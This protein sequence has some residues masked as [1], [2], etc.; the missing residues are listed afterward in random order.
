MSTWRMT[1]MSY[2][3]NIGFRN[4]EDFKIKDGDKDVPIVRMLL[5]K[6]ILQGVEV[7][8]LQQLV[9]PTLQVTTSTDDI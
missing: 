4:K 3:L 5:S 2:R 7:H 1:L 8:R 6:V 9:M